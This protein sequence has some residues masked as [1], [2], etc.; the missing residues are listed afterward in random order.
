M[1]RVKRWKDIR[2]KKLSPEK[3]VAIDRQV[4]EELL[5]MDL[6]AI[7]ELIGKT[8]VELAEAVEMTQSQVSRIECRDDHRVSTLRRIVEALGGELEL[9]ATFGDKRLRLRAA[10]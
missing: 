4:E 1:T 10:G 6:R 3:L 2:A 9:I 7:R 8:Q 5:E